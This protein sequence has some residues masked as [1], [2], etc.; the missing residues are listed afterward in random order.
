MLLRLQLVEHRYLAVEAADDFVELRVA[1]LYD[2]RDVLLYRLVVGT[3]APDLGRAYEV[4]LL[5][6]VAVILSCEIEVV[7]L[8][9]PACFLCHDLQFQ[10]GLFLPG[11]LA[12]PGYFR[13]GYTYCS[14]SMVRSS[15]CAVSPVKAATA[16]VICCMSV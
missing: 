10:L 12:L 6:L 7:R 11:L 15:L 1:A 3:Y 5:L 8:F 2:E 13:L 14:A 9:G 16:W 4:V